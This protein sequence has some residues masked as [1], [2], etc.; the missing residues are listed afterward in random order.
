MKDKKLTWVAGAIGAVGL[1]MAL[2]TSVFASPMAPLSCRVHSC[3]IEAPGGRVLGEGHCGPY[4]TGCGC[5]IGGV[6]SS[7]SACSN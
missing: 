7:Q 3:T 5:F 6:G 2:L 1:A 4:D